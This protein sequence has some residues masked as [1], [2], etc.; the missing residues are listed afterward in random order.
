MDFFRSKPCTKR[1][2]FTLIELLIVVAILA[3]LAAVAVPNFLEAQTRAKVSR[4]LTDMR[5]IAVTLEA[6]CVD[7]NDYPIYYW[8]EGRSELGD[9][10]GTPEQNYGELAVLTTPVAY[11]A[12]IPMDP[13]HF[14]RGP[15]PYDYSNVAEGFRR[16]GRATRTLWSLRG[17]GPDQDRDAMEYYDPTNGTVSNG[18]VSLTN[19]GFYGPYGPVR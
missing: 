17:F 12:A 15:R 3:I 11:L 14:D 5:S 13:F 8:W 6:Y 19:L 9:L 4:C 7:W 18:D 2:A 1:C 16:L 10:L